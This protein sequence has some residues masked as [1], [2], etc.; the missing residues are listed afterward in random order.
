MGIERTPCRFLGCSDSQTPGKRTES[1]Q[2]A[3]PGNLRI[4][5]RTDLDD[6]KSTCWSDAALVSPSTRSGARYSTSLSLKR[7]TDHST[8]RGSCFPRP[9]LGYHLDDHAAKDPGHRI[10]R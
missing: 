2:K 7:S 4:G 9:P 8:C 5:R 10:C 6:A 3:S 1:T